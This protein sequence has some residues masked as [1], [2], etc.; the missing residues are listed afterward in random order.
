[1]RDYVNGQFPIIMA[2]NVIVGNG[3]TPIPVNMREFQEG[4]VIYWGF[5]SYVDGNYKL[6]VEASSDGGSSGTPVDQS[7]H[8]IV[9]KFDIDIGNDPTEV[10][11]TG[12]AAQ[13]F[14]FGIKEWPSKDMR[15]VLT[16]T[17]VT[18]GAE[19]IVIVTGRGQRS[20]T[21]SAHLKS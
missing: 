17:G 13:I 4:M 3:V 16:S 8:I 11:G 6:T 19:I 5:F 2:P 9:S 21:D 18:S 15:V 7:R 20:P 10:L 12:A 1:M 14:S